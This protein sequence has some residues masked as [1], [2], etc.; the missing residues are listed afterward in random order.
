[1]DSKAYTLCFEIL[2]TKSKTELKRESFTIDFV[3][4]SDVQLIQ[5]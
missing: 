4:N 2:G 1:M 5:N 3:Y